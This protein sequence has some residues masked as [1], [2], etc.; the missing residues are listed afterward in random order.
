M[1]VTVDSDYMKKAFVEI[2]RDYYSHWGLEALLDYY[3]KIDENMEFEP[4]NIWCDCVEY[5]EGAGNSLDD[6]IRDWGGEYTIQ[7]WL[8][9]ND[10]SDFTVS[11]Y[12]QALVKNLKKKTTVLHAANGNYIIFAF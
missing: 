7:D 10:E 4:G 12:I 1:K 2:G 9:E 6:L 3:N 5:G 8:E 11:R